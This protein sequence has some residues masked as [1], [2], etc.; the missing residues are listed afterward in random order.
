MDYWAFLRIVAGFLSLHGSSGYDSRGGD[1]TSDTPELRTAV[2]AEMSACIQESLRCEHHRA[3][4][5]TKLN[6]SRKSKS[7]SK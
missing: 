2:I 7:H 3:I 1:Q 4:K 5:T 6:P